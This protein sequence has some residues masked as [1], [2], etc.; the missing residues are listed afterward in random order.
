MTWTLPGPSPTE[1]LSNSPEETQDLG[2]RIARSLG[3][4]CVLAL[5]GGLGAGK[6]CFAKGFARGL[7][8]GEEVTSPTYTIV[9]EYEAWPAAG[10]PVPLYHIDAYR[11]SGEDDFE[12][13]GG[14]DLLYGG[15]ICLIEWSERIRGALP[16]D[17]ILISFEMCGTTSRIIRVSKGIP[18]S[19]AGS[20]GETTS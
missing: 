19:G 7:G 12:A 18:P 16:P 4:G 14:R 1:Y 9:S 10:S 11:L 13:L 20:P 5:Q 3:P 17:C 2:E 6:T 15:G 8:V